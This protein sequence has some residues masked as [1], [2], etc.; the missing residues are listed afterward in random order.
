ME[1][2]EQK[3]RKCVIN[4]AKYDKMR[5]NRTKYYET[6]AVIWIVMHKFVNLHRQNDS[7]RCKLLAIGMETYRFSCKSIK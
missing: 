4:V 2:C 6:C 1:K 7:K 5:K 3:A